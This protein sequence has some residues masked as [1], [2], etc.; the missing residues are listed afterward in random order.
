MSI[1]IIYKLILSFVMGVAMHAQS[2]QNKYELSLQYVKKKLSYE[3]DVYMLIN[4]K[5][6]YMVIVLFLMG[7]A[8]HTQITSVNLQ[9]TVTF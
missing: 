8:R 5:V 6:F 7:L 2:A 9:Y 3:V 1:T 4:V